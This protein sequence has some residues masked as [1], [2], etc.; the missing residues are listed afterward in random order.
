MGLLDGNPKIK[1]IDLER[2]GRSILDLDDQKRWNWVS[3]F[4]DG[5]ELSEK[6]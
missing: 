1:I 3:D 4:F 5:K 2:D 6:Y